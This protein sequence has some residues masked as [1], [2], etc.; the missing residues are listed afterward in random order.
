[1]KVLAFRLFGDF[2]HFRA[3]YTTSSPTT[4]SLMPPTSIMGVIG[5]ILGL[6]KN[7]EEYYRQ[8]TAKGT[9][10]GINLEKSVS[11]LMMST[12]LINTKGN[13]WVPTG[14]NSSGP[15]T[16][17]RYEYVRQ[18]EYMIYVTMQD[19]ALLN[20][21]AERIKNHCLIYTVSLGLANLIADVRFEFYEE[22]F[23]R[24]TEGYQTMDCAVPLADLA[25]ERPILIEPEIQYCKERYV[26]YFLPDRV[27][28][29]YV[30]VLFTI[31]GK[32]V[33]AKPTGYCEAGG[34]KIMFMNKYR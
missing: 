30:D 20:E 12:N 1:M 29:A 2:A 17:T 22:A 15:R 5:A 25:A 34:K 13:Y 10:V 31:N 21:L 32:K 27:P 26:E 14:R 4:Y 8:L 9:L 16:P 6:P 24:Q 11:K 18:P 28:G 19:E 7:E 33:T 23:V 3:Y